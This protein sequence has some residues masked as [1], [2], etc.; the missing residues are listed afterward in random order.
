VVHAPSG[1]LQRISIVGCLF[2]TRLSGDLPVDLPPGL[3]IS[4]R[5]PLFQE[6]DAPLSREGC[7]ARRVFDI[8]VWWWS[9]LWLLLL[10]LLLLLLWLLLLLLWL[11]LLLLLLLMLMLMLLLSLCVL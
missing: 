7:F 11:L 5:S 10:W 1:V 4:F 2:S 3:C 9:M 8:L 6:L